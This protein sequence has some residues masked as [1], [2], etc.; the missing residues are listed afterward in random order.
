[1]DKIIFWIKVSRPGLWFP[2]L[3][4][5]FLPLSG[6]RVWESM[7]FWLGII[8]V[9]FPLNF[10]IYGWNDYVDHETDK[11]N[12]RKDSFL[13]GAKGSQ[14]ELDTLPPLLAFFQIAF[15]GFFIYWLGLHSTWLFAALVLVMLAYNFPKKGFR[16][17]PPLELFAQFGYL[18]IV[19]FS[20]MLNDTAAVP[21]LTYAYLV[22]FAIQSQLIGEVMDIEPD[23]Q[24]NRNT[25]A[26]KLGLKNTKILI[27]LIVALEVGLL[28]FAYDDFI[29]GGMLALGLVWLLVDLFIIFKNQKYTLAQMKLF[30]VGSNLIAAVSM[31]YV[32]WS[33]VLMG[34]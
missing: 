9:T 13:F 11:L 8:F 5:Y 26:T 24:A 28:M 7:D 12:P 31:A 29:F 4:L 27:I 22:L 2:A 1:M 6:M 10:I 15:Y 18:L 34:I 16:N 20:V 33:G 3:W 19:P 32:W 25:S 21:L 17:M 14:E 30:G 23:R